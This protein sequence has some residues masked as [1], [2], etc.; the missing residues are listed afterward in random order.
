[1]ISWYKRIGS[2]AVVKCYCFIPNPQNQTQYKNI[3]VCIHSI[4]IFP[5]IIWMTVFAQLGLFNMLQYHAYLTPPSM[6]VI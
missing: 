1:M 3:T 6:R 4:F 2:A 5:Y